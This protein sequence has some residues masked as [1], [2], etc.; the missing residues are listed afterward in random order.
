MLVR[1]V[2]TAEYFVVSYSVCVAEV[3]IW[4]AVVVRVSGAIVDFAPDMSKS[5]VWRSQPGESPGKI[6]NQLCRGEVS[7]FPAAVMS[8]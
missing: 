1:H 5:E 7:L 6:L 3:M 2:P 8:F 4:P